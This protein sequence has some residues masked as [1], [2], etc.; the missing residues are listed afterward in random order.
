MSDLNSILASLNPI[1]LDEMDSVK[2]MD[3]SDTKF[4]FHS[5]RLPLLLSQVK[6]F[7]RVLDIAGNRL[8]RYETLYY[9]YPDFLL[10]KKHHNGK[11]NRHKVRFR[12]Y[13]DSG[14]C[15]FE[16]KFKSNK[17]KTKKVRIKTK[18]IALCIDGEAANFLND[19]SK[20][21]ATS[22]F[23]GVRI[24]YSRITLVS[25]FRS[26]RLTIDLGLSYR[27]S[28]PGHPRW[29]DDRFITVDNLAI[30]EVKQEKFSYSTHFF[31]VMKNNRIR[32]ARLSKY[33][34]GVNLLY[35]EVKSN[36]FKERLLNVRRVTLG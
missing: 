22:L 28:Q 34:T 8:N 10:Y 31:A 33:C 15:Y 17:D 24:N 3:R 13:T 5:T 12:E 9:D 27:N 29:S 4:I 35:P 18:K 16:V 32:T 20:M 23:P 36:R 30:A 7:Y 26:E 21:E 6:P 25:K 14:K 19:C 2:L 11:L 1:T